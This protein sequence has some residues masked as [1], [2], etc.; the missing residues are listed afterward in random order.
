MRLRSFESFGL[1]KYG[2]LYSYPS[3]QK[4]LSTEIVVVGGGITGALIS[5]ALLEEG[6]KV[7][8]VDRRDIGQ[9]STA[10]TTSMLQ[11]EIDVPM[12]LLAEK[13][14]EAGAAVCYK[15]GIAAIK[16]V[17]KLIK[18]E[19]IDCG[20]DRKQSLYAA[21]NTN[22]AK[23]LKKEFTIREKYQLGVEWLNASQIKK[24]YGLKTY[25]GILSQTA[26]SMDAYKLAHELIWKNTNRGLQVYDQTEVKKFDYK[27][28]GVEMVTADGWK[29]K[30]KK[31]VF[32]SGFETLGIL[33]E[34]IANIFSTFACVSET[35]IRINPNLNNLL[36]WDTNDPYFYMRT[37]ADGRLL[38]GG[39]D[40][41]F[42]TPFIFE[43]QKRRKAEKLI[44]KLNEFLPGVKFVQDYSWAGAFGT[45]KDGLPYIGMHPKFNN[46]IFVLGFGGNG[47]TFSIQ[48]M[49]LVKN[50]LNGES[51]ELLNHY[52]FGR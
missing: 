21:H 32:C 43:Y 7:A 16:D 41:K 22:A 51:S 44:N 18:K 39:E 52:R 35:D 15:A 9:G 24:E 12:Y 27:K 3:L 29:V 19:K 11:Y 17:E 25:G 45:T 14:G 28:H 50:L 2:L 5:H 13:I 46:A 20:F 30:C 49:Q 48:G 8:I 31:V 34:K 47:I 36:V 4:N 37:T 23:W 26:A 40:S 10:A 33:N 38:I 1:I 6:Y 42:N